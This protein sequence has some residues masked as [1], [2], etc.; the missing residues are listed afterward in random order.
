[1]LVDC[2]SYNKYK[3]N[4]AYWVGDVVGVGAAVVTLGASTDIRIP[5]SWASRSNATTRV[6]NSAIPIVDGAVPKI[7]TLTSRYG[8]DIES[9]ALKNGA[10]GI[11]NGRSVPMG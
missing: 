2:S 8:K 5:S 9:T 3:D 11:A 4:S 6:A 7:A 1:M 10:N